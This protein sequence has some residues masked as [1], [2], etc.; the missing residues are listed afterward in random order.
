LRTPVDNVD[1]VNPVCTLTSGA[2]SG[3]NRCYN[4]IALKWHNE[5]RALRVNTNNLVLDK[6]IA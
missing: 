4:K 5:Q 6:E 1:N 3:Y 2:D